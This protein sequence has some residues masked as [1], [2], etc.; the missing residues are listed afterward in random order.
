MLIDHQ[1][2]EKQLEA[3]VI[4]I[5]L[6]SVGRGVRVPRGLHDFM[7]LIW[8]NVCCGQD[9]RAMPTSRAL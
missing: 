6:V 3:K 5:S 7:S 9:S 1:L 8:G 4:G 2:L